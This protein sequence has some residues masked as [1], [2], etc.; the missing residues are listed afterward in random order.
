LTRQIVIFVPFIDAFGGVERQV[1]DL[2]RFLHAAGKPHS[3]LCLGCSI[4][5]ASHADWPIDLQV[6]AP[7]R[8]PIAE[9]YALARYF[10][11]AA[12]DAVQAPLFFDLKGA[13]YAGLFRLPDFHLHLTDPPSLLSKDVSK[14]APSMRGTFKSASRE[15]PGIGIALR[16]E[17]VHRIIK[18]GV[19][20]ARAVIATTHANAA[21]IGARYGKQALVVHPGV[22]PPHGKFQA[23]GDKLD[24]LHFLSVSR[25]EQSKRIDWMLR[26][27]AA[28]ETSHDPLSAMTDWRLDVVGDGPQRQTLPA[29]ATDLGLADRVVFHG[30]VSDAQLDALYAEASVFLMPAVQGFGLPASESL[31]RGVPVVLHRE[32][33]VSELLNT[34][35]WI[36]VVERGADDLAQAIRRMVAN[37][38]SGALRSAPIPRV[39]LADEWA[40]KVMTA[41][42]WS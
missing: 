5:L 10:K 17:I 33:G 36:E 25:L 15:S 22:Q 34:P 18:R 35:P 37:I 6:L 23:R 29:L 24:R 9:A 42:G 31:V 19:R 41:C 32:S 1:L 21:E 27:L 14:F 3:I 12:N 40:K 39:P 13:F 8:N 30:R 11:N 28:I 26:A 38:V 2:S 20:R 4:D 16:G 7:P